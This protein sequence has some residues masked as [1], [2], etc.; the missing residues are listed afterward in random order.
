MV[1]KERVDLPIGHPCSAIFLD[2]SGSVSHD[3][4]FAVGCLK[5]ETPSVLIRQVE[6][7]R[8][9]LHWYDE[10]HFTDLTKGKLSHYES[11]VDLMNATSMEFSCF[12][13]DRHQA[14]P[15]TRFGSGYAAYEKL[16]TQL[17]IGT[18]KP[19]E[20]VSVMAD[21]YSAPDHVRFEE[22]VRQE[23]NGR[24]GRTA[25]TTICRL[26]SH[27]AIPLQLVD[28]LTSAVA[29]EFRQSA[30][31]AQA[32]SPKAK[33]AKHVRDAFGV[34]SFLK[35]TNGSLNVKIYTD[36]STGAQTP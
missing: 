1:A 33:L 6:K 10:I 18:I 35:G 5:L 24:L 36:G 14:D 11:V 31:F 17:L 7:L 25:I 27:A 29:F 20:V 2:E 28:L 21:N 12:I 19:V 22:D 16:A 26:D 34:K 9:R 32:G 4:F 3:R 13:A 30:G 15:V 8:D 23:V